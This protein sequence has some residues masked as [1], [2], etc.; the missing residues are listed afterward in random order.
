MTSISRTRA[1]PALLVAM[2]LLS[3]ACTARDGAPASAAETTDD[4]APGGAVSP[5]PPRPDAPFANTVAQ[6]CP[7]DGQVRTEMALSA[8][9]VHVD[10]SGAAP[11]VTFAVDRWFTDDLGAVVGLWAP[12]FVGQAGQD[13]LL[14]TTRYGLTTGDVIWCRSELWSDEA[15]VRWEVAWGGSVPA[16]AN[17]PENPAD[18]AVLARIDE[19]ETRWNAAGITSWTATIALSQRS[20]AWSDEC[21]SGSVRVVVVD[22]LVVQAI[23]PER[24]C[25]V[26]P[27][28]A[29]TISR[30]FLEARRAAGALQG[31]MVFDPDLGF[32]T[33]MSA[34]DRS[35]ELW[36]SVSDFLP[37]ALPLAE[38][39]EDHAE[40]RARWDAAAISDYTAQVTVLCFCAI[41]GTFT[42]EVTGG[43]VVVTGEDGRRLDAGQASEFTVAGM[44]AQIEQTLGDGRAEVAYDPDLGFPVTVFLDRIEQAIDD[45]ISFRI[46]EL[47]PA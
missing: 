35:V 12:D 2:A 44:F 30:L 15:F 8:R 25:T 40:A 14:E 42:V 5:L 22:D 26:P 11:W 23:N 39:D 37:R 16:G 28:R 24:G 17:T 34:L 4:G 7:D 6:A 33:S 45:E 19:A 29:P 10:A 27:G 31:E 36:L 21:V 38:D 9:V 13:W 18:P 46:D 43:E 1:A 47:V 41:G 3:G 32:I 20:T